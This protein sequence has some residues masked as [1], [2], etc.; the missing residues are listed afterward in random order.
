[1]KPTVPLVLFGWPLVTLLLFLVMRPRRAVIATFLL[2]VLFLPIAGFKMAGLP[3]YTKMTATCLSALLGVLAFD[4][5]RLFSFRPQ[6][7]DL[8]MGIWCVCPMFSSLTND[9]GLH[10]GF[11]SVFYQTFAW[12]VPY[13]LGRIYLTDLL[14]MYELAF[15]IFL[16]G[17]VYMPLCLLEVRLSPQ[18]HTWVYGFHQHSFGQSMRFGGYRPTVFMDHGLM[19]GFWMSMATLVGFWLWFSGTKRTLFRIPMLWF[20]VPLAGTTLLCK[21]F[22]AIVLLI[23]GVGVLIATRSTSSRV[24]VVSLALAPLLYMVLRI[25]GLWSGDHLTELV[26]AV[27]PGRA[28]SLQFRLDNEDRLVKR[29]Q[30]R[31]MFGWGG[32]GRARVRDESGRDISVTDGLWIIALGN[33]GFVGLTSLMAYFL[34]T[35]G[36]L[37][38][39]F[40]AVAWNHRYVAP[41]V[42]MCVMVLL[43]LVDCLFNAMENPA[44][45]LAGGGLACLK[46]GKVKS[47]EPAVSQPRDVRWLPD[48]SS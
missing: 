45:T 5:R 41:A 44:Y 9:L 31:P 13:L 27:N 24:F 8:P 30:I 26:S 35:L 20:L 21:S 4:P 34:S 43:F 42:A 11:T 15:G 29:A 48:S 25:P 19:V 38:R 37:A 3:A 18:L 22:G 2:A 32:W 23:V 36:G 46:L 47:P 40:S 17:L 16:G 28:S 33:T 14:G 1:M 10:D 39:R 6:W 7:I 12:G